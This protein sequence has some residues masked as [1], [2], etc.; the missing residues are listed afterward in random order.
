MNVQQLQP[1]KKLKKSGNLFFSTK[2]E[3]LSCSACLHAGGIPTRHRCMQRF[4]SGGYY[5][6]EDSSD[7][8]CGIAFCLLCGNERGLEEGTYRCA[9]HQVDNNEEQLHDV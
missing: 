6:G 8:I 5:N 2:C 7:I 3:E 4:F 9:I 1:T